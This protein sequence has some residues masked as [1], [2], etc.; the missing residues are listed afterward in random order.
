MIT[1]ILLI[2][3]AH[4]AT[5]THSFTPSIEHPYRN[6]L[7]LDHLNINHQKSRH[8]QLIAFYFDFLQ[9]GVDVSYELAIYTSFRRSPH[10][11]CATSSLTECMSLN[12]M[13]SIISSI[14]RGKLRIWKRGKRHCGPISEH[15]N[16]IYQKASPTLKYWKGKFA[17]ASTKEICKI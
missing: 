17:F 8:D 3:F 13:F 16:F 14:S 11:T 5:I 12:N 10:S 6:I 1:P 2:I 7:I 9:C 4:L 15:N